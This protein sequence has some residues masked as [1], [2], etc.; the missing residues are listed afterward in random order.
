L[1]GRSGPSEGREANDTVVCLFFSFF[2][3]VYLSPPLGSPKHMTMVQI[4]HPCILAISRP[5]LSLFMHMPRSSFVCNFTRMCE[6]AAYCVVLSVAPKEQG[7]WALPGMEQSSNQQLTAQELAALCD[8][9][10]TTLQ[11][12]SPEISI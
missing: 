6:L 1:F 5:W 8:P 12:C 11:L 7:Q 4:L 3:S 2:M 10:P 9:L